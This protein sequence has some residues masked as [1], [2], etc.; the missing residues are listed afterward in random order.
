MQ[1][2]SFH[3]LREKQQPP[4]SPLNFTPFCICRTSEVSKVRSSLA[5]HNT[6]ISQNPFT[7]NGSIH[8]Q[9]FPLVQKVPNQLQ[10]H[11]QDCPG[12]AVQ[13]NQDGCRIAN[14]KLFV[15]CCLQSFTD[16]PVPLHNI[17]LVALPTSR[18]SF[19]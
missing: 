18:T 4:C 16:I 14:D 15:F 1:R 19:L 11:I 12:A 6:F 5:R 17:L 3:I 8:S 7:R 9:P 13:N 10:R 2:Y